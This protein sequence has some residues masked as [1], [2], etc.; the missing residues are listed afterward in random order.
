MSIGP[1]YKV[2]RV[3]ERAKRAKADYEGI[4]ANERKKRS[5][6]AQDRVQHLSGIV[7][8]LNWMIDELRAEIR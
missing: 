4:L 8:G 3:I 5:R 6:K 7:N 2:C 1:K